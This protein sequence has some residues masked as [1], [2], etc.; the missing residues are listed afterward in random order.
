MKSI[1]VI[2][3]FT[4]TAG[5]SANEMNKERFEKRKAKVV[6]MAEERIKDLQTLKSCVSKAKE[7]DA[8]KK[9]Q[10][11]HREKIMSE[12]KSRKEMR[13]ERKEKRQKKS[14]N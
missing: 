1:L 6:E 2:L 7:R 9:C 3:I 13:K 11:T 10:E 8:L 4:I 5:V 14:E 12:M